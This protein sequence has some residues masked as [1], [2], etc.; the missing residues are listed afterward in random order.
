MKA[1]VMSLF[2]L[3]LLTSNFAEAQELRAAC[4]PAHYGA[5]AGGE[6]GLLLGVGLTSALA[7][8]IGV[9]GCTT[10][11]WWTAGIGCGVSIVVGGIAGA[12]I[13]SKL[14][15]ETGKFLCY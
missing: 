5:V 6:L 11:G 2:L 13:G 10:T 7:T 1:F 3:F 15:E 12:V 9:V 4:R 8:H 14:G